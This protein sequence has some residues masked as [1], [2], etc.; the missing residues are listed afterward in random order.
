MLSCGDGGLFV[1][2]FC[3]PRGLSSVFS[4]SFS[5]SLSR[6]SFFLSKRNA[7]V[8][9][10][11]LLLA[12]FL[13]LSFPLANGGTTNTRRHRR[14]GMSGNEDQLT[15]LD[16]LYLSRLCVLEGGGLF[17]SSGQH[18]DATNAS[19]GHSREEEEEEAGGG[20]T[21]EEEGGREGGGV[22][23]PP[24][25]KTH[26]HGLSP[27]SSANGLGSMVEPS[28]EL[29]AELFKNVY[30]DEDEESEGALV[31]SEVDHDRRTFTASGR[32]GRGCA[33]L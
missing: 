11:V 22:S 21:R 9:S 8:S 32:C 18:L 2:L 28:D 16:F 26:R 30:L 7:L 17:P 5:P 12:L 29:L 15:G 23:G 6:T 25:A 27:A 10:S 13:S 1:Y 19:D 24:R 33:A 31:C 4:F 14:D 20:A 3:H